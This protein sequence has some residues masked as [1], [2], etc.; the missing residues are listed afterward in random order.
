MSASERGVD[1]PSAIED[2]IARGIF[3]RGSPAFD[4]AQRV[5]STGYDSLTRKQRQLYDAVVIPAL[6]R[7]QSDR[8]PRR[9]VSGQRVTALT[10]V[11]GLV[12]WR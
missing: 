1:L 4:I 11:A 9:G 6:K 5:I 10:G 2:L 8:A 3:G 12:S 7:R